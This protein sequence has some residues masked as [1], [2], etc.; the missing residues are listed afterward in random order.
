MAVGFRSL[1][2]PI[3]A[4]LAGSFLSGS[5]AS[6][7]DSHY[8][9]EFYGT[10]STILS[11]VVVGSVEELAAVYYNPARLGSMGNPGVILSGKVHDWSLLEIE[12]AL[13][14]GLDLSTSKFGGVPS[15]AA[16]TFRILLLPKHQFGYA[17]L[18]KYRNSADIFV[19]DV[20]EADVVET[21]PGSEA[22]D[23][24]LFGVTETKAE[25]FGGSWS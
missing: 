20:G 15:L 2:H 4:G 6:A 13:G 22:V 19:R 25:W 24:K 8:W 7:Q 14:E 9:T 3:L 21:F 17:F 11:G 1:T 10:R 18:T 16:G 5:D 12:D 23:E